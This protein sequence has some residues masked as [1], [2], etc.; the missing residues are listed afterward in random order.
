M[1]AALS[2]PQGAHYRADVKATL[3][4][5]RRKWWSQLVFEQEAILVG[6]IYHPERS[7]GCCPVRATGGSL[8]CGRYLLALL[9]ENKEG[10]WGLMLL[11]FYN[12]KQV[13]SV[14]KPIP[15]SLILVKG[16]QLINGSPYDGTK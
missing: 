7:H 12:S 13:E 14:A 6:I 10:A 4:S 5:P 15:V 9:T 1:D 3:L 11:G 16:V 8:P 2:A